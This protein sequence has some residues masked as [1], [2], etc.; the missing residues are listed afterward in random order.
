MNNTQTYDE[1][2]IQI[3]EKLN[4]KDFKGAL[5]VCHQGQEKF[6][7]K[8]DFEFIAGVCHKN[9]QDFDDAKISF[10]NAIELNDAFFPSYDLLTDIL[11]NQ[12]Q[13]EDTFYAYE[14]INL[15]EKANELEPNNLEIIYKLALMKLDLA[16]Y[17]E[18]IKLLKHL[19]E[20]DP[21]EFLY[22]SKLAQAYSRS[23]QADKA[24][25]L[26]NKYHEHNPE[27]LELLSQLGVAM[28]S[29][30]NFEEARK[31][32]KDLLSRS[33]LDDANEFRF[34]VV[35]NY[36]ESL[37]ME[38]DKKYYEEYLSMVEENLL[39]FPNSDVMQKHFLTANILCENTEVFKKEDEFLNSLY[40]L[41]REVAMMNLFLSDHHDEIDI[42]EFCPN[43]FDCLKTYNLKNFN[44][45]HDELLEKALSSI[46]NQKLVYD[47]PFKTDVNASRTEK[48]LSRVGDEAIDNIIDLVKSI[49]LDYERDIKSKKNG[50][51]AEKWPEKIDI[52]S[53]S[54]IAGKDAYHIKHNHCEAWFSAVLYLKVPKNLSDN[55]G[56]IVFTSSGLNF[57]SSN[58]T[59]EIIVNPKEGDVVFFPAHLTHY[60]KPFE[61]SLERVCMPFNFC[62]VRI[63]D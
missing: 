17:S 29:K 12:A 41:D 61:D 30:E 8:F 46:R 33:S 14:A 55:Q 63:T 15:L 58:K 44:K 60:T 51:Y 26:I 5:E 38:S 48:D 62:P 16:Y 34:A 32:Y 43:T 2:N 20:L 47:Q 42:S 45:N 28:H 50:Y 7:D 27:R 36:C 18:S 49:S 19:N 31:I 39:F 3:E 13:T 11:T 22:V 59:K 56:S 6:P 24:I 1:L 57:P 35:N 54:M 53:W 21:N 52:K 10:R 25:E 37:R 40:P 9:L 4:L 23:G